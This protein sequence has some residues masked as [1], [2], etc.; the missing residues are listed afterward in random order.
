MRQIKSLLRDTW[1][2]WCFF[3]AFSIFLAVTQSW[4]FYLRASLA[5]IQHGLLRLHALRR[6]RQLPQ[7]DL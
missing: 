1:F 3:A 2:M 5:P 6:P 4:I 7:A